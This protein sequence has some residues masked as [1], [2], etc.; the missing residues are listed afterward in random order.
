MSSAMIYNKMAEDLAKNT[1]DD[2]LKYNI[3]S[4]GYSIAADC[5]DT[6]ECLNYAMQAYKTGQKL[7][8]NNRMAYPANYITMS[9]NELNMQDSVQKYMSVCLNLIDYFNMGA[10]ASVYASFG[11]AMFKKEN[12]SIAEQYYLESV[13]IID[14]ACA[15]KGLTMIHLRRNNAEKA[16]ECYAKALRPNSFESNIDI[17][18]EYAAF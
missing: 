14:N 16:K 8:D 15:Y 9:Y 13:G 12:D 3:Y 6:Q 1:D 17:M 18:S 2:I 4:T 7:R 11:D 5:F 10:K